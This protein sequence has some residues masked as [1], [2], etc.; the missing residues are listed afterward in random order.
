MPLL[1]RTAKDKAS[2]KTY[3]TSTYVSAISYAMYTYA[4]RYG[5]RQGLRQDACKK[6]DT[7]RAATYSCKYIAV[8]MKCNAPL[9]HE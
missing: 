2:A 6:T 5:K 8:G 1:R 3:A 9:T 4:L 7:Y